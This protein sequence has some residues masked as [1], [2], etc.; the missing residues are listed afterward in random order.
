MQVAQPLP[1]QAS[2]NPAC[3]HPGRRTLPL[4]SA[5]FARAELEPLGDIDQVDITSHRPQVGSL[6]NL[7]MHPWWVKV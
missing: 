2:V 1:G 7:P 5:S 6:Q 4:G 3:F